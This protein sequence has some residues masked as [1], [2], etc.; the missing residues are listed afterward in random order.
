MKVVLDS[1]VLIAVLNQNDSTHAECLSLVEKLDNEDWE[2]LAPVLYLWEMHAYLR[3]PEKSKTH[4]QNV[5]ATFKVTTYDVTSDLY[6]RTYS[7]QTVNITGADRVFVSLAKDHGVPL[8]TN[9][10]KILKGAHLLGVKAMSVA[11]FLADASS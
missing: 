11:G 9:D 4:A 8:V 5:A 3:H 7:T 6:Y 1:N 2:V 10:D